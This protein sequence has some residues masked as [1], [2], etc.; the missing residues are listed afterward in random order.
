LKKFILKEQKKGVHAGHPL[1]YLPFYLLFGLAFVAPLAFL[2]AFGA[3][4][5]AL[6]FVAIFVRYV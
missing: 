4:F 6:A 5:L 2:A 3:A 1:S